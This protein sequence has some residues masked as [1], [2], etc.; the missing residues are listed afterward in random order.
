MSNDAPA[1][2]SVIVSWGPMLLLIAVWIFFMRKY[3]PRRGELRNNQYL[4][5]SLEEQKRHNEA[6]EKILAEIAR[7]LP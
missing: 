7:R 5:A 3:L 4:T 1:I 6:L 2:I